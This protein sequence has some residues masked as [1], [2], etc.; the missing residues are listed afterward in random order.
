M[1]FDIY[2]NP[3]VYNKAMIDNGF[4]VTKPLTSEQLYRFFKER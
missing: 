3:E 4:I 1:W 2:I